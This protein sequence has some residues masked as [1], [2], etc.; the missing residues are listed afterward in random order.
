[1]CDLTESAGLSHPAVPYRLM[2]LTEVGFVTREK[3]GM[4][5]C[6][7]IVPGGVDQLARHLGGR[8]AGEL[9]A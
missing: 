8:L 3:H 4:W 7:T 2:V 6:C 5:V 9:P 1:M